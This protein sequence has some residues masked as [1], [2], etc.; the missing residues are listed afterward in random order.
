[1]EGESHG[2]DPVMERAVD[3]AAVITAARERGLT[4][5]TAESLTAGALVARLVDVPGSSAVIAGGA[6]CY[7]YAAKSRVLGVDDT[8]LE[9]EGAVTAVVARQMAAGARTLYET[10]VAID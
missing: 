4:I 6:A 9:R 10:D 5:S 8:L 7:S 2:P 1:M 3:P